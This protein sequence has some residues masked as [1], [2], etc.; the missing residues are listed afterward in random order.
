MGIS[1]KPLIMANAGKIVTGELLVNFFHLSWET[2]ARPAF[3]DKTRYPGIA[4]QISPDGLNLSLCILGRLPSHN[5]AHL[6][7]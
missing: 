3:A 4:F 1:R 7:S 5:S 2:I 6:I